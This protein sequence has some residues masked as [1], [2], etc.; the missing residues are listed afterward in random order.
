VSSEPGAGHIEAAKNVFMFDQTLL[1]PKIF[2]GTYTKPIEEIANS[3]DCEPLPDKAR[4]TVIETS[5]H[6]YM[7]F[8]AVVE[9][10]VPE[11]S[12]G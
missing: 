2:S 9:R 4:V 3:I 10:M 11:N 1:S 12:N 6:G 8:A 5:R 7:L